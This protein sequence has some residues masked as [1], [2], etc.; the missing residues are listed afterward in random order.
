M[1]FYLKFIIFSVKKT[2]RNKDYQ[3]IHHIDGRK[4]ARPEGQEAN[5]SSSP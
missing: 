3:K 1:H 4:A 5:I 2:I